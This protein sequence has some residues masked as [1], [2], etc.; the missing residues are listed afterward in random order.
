VT[1]E[2]LDDLQWRGLIAQTTDIDAL[3]R[4]L[5]AGPLTLY[6]GFDPTAPSLHLG[7]LVPL[8]ALRRW[9]HR[10]R[11][12]PERALDRAA[13]THRGHGA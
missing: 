13:A 3:R 5:V 9:R 2:I 10:T 4:D 12:R 7:S 8:L 6:C 1:A 11:R